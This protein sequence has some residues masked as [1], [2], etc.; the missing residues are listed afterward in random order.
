M[1]STSIVLPTT[2]TPINRSGVHADPAWRKAALSTVKRLARKRE[3]FTSFD[4]LERLD[5]SEVKTS[6]LRA[7]GSVMIQ[8]RNLGIISNAGLV[9]RSNKYSRGATTLWR[10]LLIQQPPEQ[11]SSPPSPLAGADH[12]TASSDSAA[13]GCAATKPE[14]DAQ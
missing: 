7:V 8:A 2:T 10:S 3:T 6:D 12:Q 14:K 4:V 1:T 5:K 13:G 11:H 9:R